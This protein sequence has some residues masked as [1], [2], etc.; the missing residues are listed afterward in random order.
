MLIGN[1]WLYDWSGLPSLSR[2]FL[3][4]RE[5]S[6]QVKQ[7]SPCSPK[8]T[9][10]ENTISAVPPCLPEIRPLCTVPT[11]RL[12]VN[13]GIASED[14][15]GDPISPCPR[16]PIYCPAFRSALSSRNSLWMRFAVLL[17]LQWFLYQVM[18]VIHQLCAFVKNY[19]SPQVDINLRCIAP[20]IDNRNVL[21]EGQDPPLQTHTVN[22]PGQ[23]P[24]RYR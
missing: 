18:P 14:T 2:K 23:H 19:F 10:T 16:R 6:F 12:P 3:G 13:A 17:P 11:H 15:L 5:N 1:E 7:K 8:G 4:H 20:A 24:V 21:R 22:T 9:R